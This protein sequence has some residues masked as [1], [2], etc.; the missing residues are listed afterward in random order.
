MLN[1]GQVFSVWC[2]VKCS[3]ITCLYVCV[4]LTRVDD[5]RNVLKTK[6]V[7]VARVVCEQLSMLGFDDGTAA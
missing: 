3:D 2:T 7:N 4:A 6:L 1:L 5:H